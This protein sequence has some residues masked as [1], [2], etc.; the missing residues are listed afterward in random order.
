MRILATFIILLLLPITGWTQCTSDTIPP[1]AQCKSQLSVAL[2]P[3]GHAIVTAIMIDSSSTDNCGIDHY[4]INNKAVDTFDCSHVGSTNLVT[5][6]IIDSAG[7]SSTCTS[8][9]NILDVTAPTLLCPSVPVDFYLNASGSVAINPTAVATATDN[10]AILSWYIDGNSNTTFDCSH[11]GTPILVNISVED[12]SYNSAQCNALIN[13]QDTVP[14]TAMCHDTI[15]VQLAPDGI[16][17]VPATIL[18]NGSTDACSMLSYSIN[19]LLTDTFNCSHVGMNPS[20]LTVQ[21]AAGNTDNCIS[22][23][24]IVDNVAPMVTC[25]DIEVYLDATGNATLLIDSVNNSSSDNC[26]LASIIFNNGA[27]SINYTLADI[28]THAVTVIATDLSGNQDSCSAQVTVKSS[29]L[30]MGNIYADL[31]V[32]CNKEVG[33]LGLANIIVKAAGSN[34]YYG[35]TDALGNYQIDAPAGIYT[36]SPVLPSPYWK[37]C[38]IAQTVNTNSNSTVN[39]GLQAIVNCPLLEV[40]ISTPHLRKSNGGSSYTVSYCN[41]GTATATNAA[42]TVDIDPD[43]NIINSSLPIINQ[44]GNVCTFFLGA[45]PINTCESFSID[46]EV[47][48]TANDQ[49]THC[50]KVYVSIDSICLPNYWNSAIFNF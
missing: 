35:T 47:K 42:I 19:G 17:V 9:L 10:C 15:M 14:P 22:T 28:G 12:P 4:L 25:Q 20:I 29:N 32:N 8:H 18:D 13:I 49:Q 21:D 34:T 37:Y 27:S 43:L 16:A 26:A 39:F 11:I 3:A 44:V 1:T 31:N 45:V 23:I 48:H 2:T 36:V 24:E 41:R 38:G 33:E 5:L 7:N 30:L 46:V 50:S 40:D 6:T